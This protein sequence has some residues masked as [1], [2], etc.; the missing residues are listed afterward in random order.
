[1]AI[2]SKITSARPGAGYISKVITAYQNGK[3]YQNGKKIENK[4]I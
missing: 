3:Y 1:M 2:I 4:Q